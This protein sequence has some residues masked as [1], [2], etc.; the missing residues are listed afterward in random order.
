M[1]QGRRARGLPGSRPRTPSA[2]RRLDASDISSHQVDQMLDGRALLSRGS[3]LR[4][5][6]VADPEALI[7]KVWQADPAS[8]LRSLENAPQTHR[9][10]IRDVILELLDI[11]DS[12][13]VHAPVTLII[14]ELQHLTIDKTAETHLPLGRNK[15][16]GKEIDILHPVVDE[17][18]GL[19]IA[20]LSG[21]RLPFGKRIG[22]D[23]CRADPAPLRLRRDRKQ[24]C[25]RGP[26]V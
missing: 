10:H 19:E 25:L 18:D 21:K 14:L 11:V 12:S 13:R 22:I 3:G 9:V 17:P 15:E 7:Q 16:F 20:E 4:R 2:G 24:R 26:E 23:R 1:C 6:A 5:Y 8:A